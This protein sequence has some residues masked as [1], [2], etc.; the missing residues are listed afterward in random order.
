MCLE[1]GAVETLLVW[2][3]LDCERFELSGP[4]GKVD[5]KHLTAEQV[6]QAVRGHQ[7]PAKRRGCMCAGALWVV[8]AGIQLS[9]FHV[10][11]S[12]AGRRAAVGGVL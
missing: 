10:Q 8:H 7:Q 9:W 3:S 4:G 5:V 2:E 12:A 6:R 1:M 11:R